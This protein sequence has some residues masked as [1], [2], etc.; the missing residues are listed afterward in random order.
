CYRGM[1]NGF[2]EFEGAITSHHLLAVLPVRAEVLTWQ[3]AE[4]LQVLQD[5]VQA[6]RLRPLGKLSFQFQPQGVSAIVLLEE[7]HVALHFWP[8]QG[9]VTIDIH[10]CDYQE[11]NYPKAMALAERLTLALF[12]KP[13]PERWRCLS[14]TG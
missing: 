10:T 9:R 14:V 4:F 6:A 13:A 3:E 11:D 12:G 1:G 2:M 7:S 5:A 8:E